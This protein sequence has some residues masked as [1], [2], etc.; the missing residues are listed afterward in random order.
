M[1]V[2]VLIPS[3]NEE[4]CIGRV[5]DEMPRDVVSEVIIIDGHSSDNTVREARKHTHKND[6]IIIQDG[7]GYGAAFLQGLSLAKNDVVIMMDADG[8]HNPKD[9]YAIIAKFQEGYEYVM[10]SRYMA[11]GKSY[12]DTLIRYLG[13]R[14]FTTMT[15]VIHGTQVSD[16]LYLFTAA[17]KKALQAL[18]LQ[19]KG[20]EFCTEII[21]KAHKHGLKFAEVAA[22]ERPRYAGSSKVNA[23]WHGLKILSMICKSYD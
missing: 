16:S 22:I 10:A 7:Y 13:N 23:F 21:V 15:N 3:R 19:T 14:I 2:S 4:G 20:F 8:S 12:D 9:I 18:H 11:G 1:K 5:L 6:K 17:S